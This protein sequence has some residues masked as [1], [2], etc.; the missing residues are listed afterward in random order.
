RCLAVGPGQ[1]PRQLAAELQYLLLRQAGGE[2]SR[3]AAEVVLEGLGHGALTWRGL[4][5]LPHGPRG[6]TRPGAAA[7]NPAPG[8][9]GRSPTRRRPAAALRGL[10][11]TAGSESNA[12]P[13][14][15]RALQRAAPA[16]NG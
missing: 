4:Y 3:G 16:R 14:G 10:P 13:A 9:P 5:P 2:V 7:S 1:L 11:P 6:S 12:P 8:E 15:R